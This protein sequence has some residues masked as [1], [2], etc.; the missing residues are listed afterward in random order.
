MKPQI[1]IIIPVINEAAQFAETLQALQSLRE[2]C[3]LLLVDGDSIDASRSV[4]EPWVDQVL[5]SPRGRARQMNLGA[6]YAQAD[7]LLF[8]HADTQ[9]PDQAIDLIMPAVKQGAA[10][11]RF[12]VRFDSQQAVFKLIACMMNARSRW[13]GIAT[14]D[15]AIFITRQAFLAVGGFPDMALM[16]D[17]AVSA[18]LKK[19]AKPC[20]LRAKV[21]TSARRW[22]Q[23]GIL[24]TILF[25]WRLRL[26]YFFGANPD[27]LAA[28]YYRRQ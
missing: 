8:L 15:Q 2:Q 28:R 1:S 19:L 11:G 26:R 3:E 9:L 14:G 17:I 7:V 10:W 18:A 13:T 4:A 23:H 21:V 24:T 5:H 22:Q 20:C 12:D 27:D 16:E 6:Q 25:M